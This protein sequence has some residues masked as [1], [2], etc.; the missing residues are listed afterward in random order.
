MN[1]DDLRN[2]AG[3]GH[4]HSLQLMTKQLN[5]QGHR[6]RQRFHCLGFAKQYRRRCP[7]SAEGFM[8]IRPSMIKKTWTAL[9]KEEV[10]ASGFTDIVRSMFCGYHDVSGSY[11]EKQRE[12]FREL[13]RTTDIKERDAFLKAIE[14]G[15]RDIH[16][17]IHRFGDMSPDDVEDTLGRSSDGHDEGTSPKLY[18]ASK[19]E[20]RMIVYKKPQTSLDTIREMLKLDMISPE[21]PVRPW[22]YPGDDLSNGERF[23]TPSS[24]N[25]ERKNQEPNNHSAYPIKTESPD[26]EASVG[27]FGTPSRWSSSDSREAKLTSSNPPSNIERDDQFKHAA[28]EYQ[29]GED[30]I[31]KVIERRAA[32]R[33]SSPRSKDTTKDQTSQSKHGSYLFNPK[34]TS[35]AG[36]APT[37]ASTS[38]TNIPIRSISPSI[39][40]SNFNYQSDEQSKERATPPS[41]NHRVSSPP[42]RFL[43]PSPYLPKSRSASPPSTPTPILAARSPETPKST[44][45]RPVTPLYSPQ[46]LNETAEKIREILCQPVNEDNKGFIYILKAPAF[47]STFA[48]ATLRNETWLKIGISRDVPK[49][50]ASLKAQCGLFDLTEIREEDNMR[51]TEPMA[52]EQ[53]RRVERL[54]HA[55]LNNLRRKMDC[56]ESSAACNA[57]HNEW[58]AVGEELAKQTVRLWVSFIEK[59]P[60]A[61]F[62]ML[63]RFWVERAMTTTYLRLNKRDAE[64]LGVTAWGKWLEE[65]TEAISESEDRF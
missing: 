42:S 56:T 57:V 61:H 60:Y 25:L 34:T 55:H 40:Q 62:G 31:F 24:L 19:G 12:F 65:G 20:Y 45:E 3:L 30:T 18:D 2:E 54:C 5:A 44:L 22:V 26:P 37:E 50:I 59:R 21:D 11:T 1:L 6:I 46:T 33:S 32:S 28:F 39:P 9:R 36:S 23:F 27:G 52:M 13:W 16:E 64:D 35:A 29:E 15:L 53:L 48:P 10:S 63:D 8:M 14:D 17:E 43:S 51:F 49:R 7:M 4:I 41:K 38:T 58:F 47:F